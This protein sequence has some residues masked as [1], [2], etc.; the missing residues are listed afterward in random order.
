MTCVILIIPI[1]I[2]EL[3]KKNEG[4]I[5]I[6]GAA[7]VLS[8]Y[9]SFLSF[10]GTVIL[11]LVAVWQNNKASELN[12]KLQRLQQA[13]YISM[14]SIKR[15]MTEKRSIDSPKIGNKEM[16]PI[17][18]I[19]LTMEGFETRQTYHID[20]EFE[21]ASEYPIV[22]MQLHPGKRETQIGAIYGIR[23]LTDQAVYI[24]KGKNVYFRFIVPSE[25]FEMSKQ[26]G[27]ELSI[28][29]I[30]VFDYVTPAS[31]CVTDLSKTGVNV[32]FAYRLLKFT[33]VKPKI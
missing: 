21:N 11:G 8:F 22:Q 2:N 15:V 3:Y 23:N 24:S 19:D 17:N 31:L 29:F 27:L 14:V 20:V 30:N 26:Y 25:V 18:I 33:D 1:I 4:Y 7:D 28:N 12:I 5:T 6:W 32:E 13:Q 10:A 9:G 16:K